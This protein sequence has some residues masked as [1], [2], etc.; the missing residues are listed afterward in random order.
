MKQH[1]TQS[2]GEKL[3]WKLKKHLHLNWNRETILNI[4]F[5]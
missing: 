5:H 2:Y 3:E 1:P 4:F